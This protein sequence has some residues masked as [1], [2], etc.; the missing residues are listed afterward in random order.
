MSFGKSGGTSVTTPELTP[1]QRQ[2]IQA[3]NE[4]FTGTIA[5]TYEQAVR[6]ATALYE[7]GAP[8]VTTAAQNLAGVARQGQMTLGETGE[9]ALRTGIT[10]LQSL[11][12]PDYERQQ[13]DAALMPAQQQ[14]LQN[15]AAQQ[16]SFGGTGNLGSARSALAHTQLAGQ[17]QQQQQQAA[18]GVLRDIAAQ[19]AGAATNLAQFGQGGLGQALGAAGQAVTASMVPQDLYNKYSSVIFGTPQA[20]YALG[21]V[22]ENRQTSGY[23]FGVGGSY[24]SKPFGF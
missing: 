15:L 12:S 2:Q 23:Q 21:P 3:Q 7:S 1:E 10:G 13:L 17:A 8:G 18:A 5:P 20:S 16:A 19:R 4:F 14:Y 22:G 11:F 9:S 24:G 6:G